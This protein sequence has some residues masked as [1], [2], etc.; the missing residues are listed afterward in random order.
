[1]YRDEEEKKEYARKAEL[2]AGYELQKKDPRIRRRMN[3]IFL[4]I[5]IPV[6]LLIIIALI[7]FFIMNPGGIQR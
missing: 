2:R 5:I 4:C 3:I 7:I 6:V 1:M